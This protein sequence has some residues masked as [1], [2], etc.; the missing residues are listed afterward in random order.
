MVLGVRGA[1]KFNGIDLMAA[2]ISP[3]VSQALA[4]LRAVILSAI[5][6]EVVQGL[7][8]DVPPPLAGIVMT[9]LSSARLATNTHFYN[10]PVIEVGSKNIKQASQLA[11]QLDCYGPDADEWA[12]M[13]S[14]ILRDEY[15][16]AMMSSAQPLY[17]DDP[18]LIPFA[19]PGEQRYVQRWVLTAYLQYNP[20]VALPQQFFDHAEISGIH[21]VDKE[22]L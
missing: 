6:C 18:K 13:L 12:Q 7:D 9:P 17:T 19:D 15:S 22:T 16:R 1:P 4:E 10:D 14:T 3:T 8:N 2:T 11:I 5:S 20:V 21:S